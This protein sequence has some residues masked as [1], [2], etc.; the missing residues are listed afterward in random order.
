M[1]VERH[2]F[3]TLDLTTPERLTQFEQIVAKNTQ[4]CAYVHRINLV[5][6][7]E[8]YDLAAR[9]RFETADEH[10]LNNGFFASAIQTLF[11]ILQAW[12]EDHTTRG[13][14]L[15]IKAQSPSDTVDR[16][17]VREARRNPK[18]DLRG[19]RY[20]KNYLQFAEESLDGLAAVSAVTELSVAAAYA[21][22]RLIAPASCALIA[23]KLPRLRDAR[24]EL[25]DNEKR[26]LALR[27]RNRNGNSKILNPD[28]T[29]GV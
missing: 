21:Q 15:S 19:R 26:D 12:P 14:H 17:R 2:T 22:Q 29:H 25:R 9:A 11:G 5:V 4:R 8:A 16:T 1:A 24:L 20:E 23:S 3:S 10:G 27:K 6:Q 7:L 18:K 28:T 13:I